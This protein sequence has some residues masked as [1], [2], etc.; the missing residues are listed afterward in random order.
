VLHAPVVVVLEMQIE[1]NE[2][3][4]GGCFG[5]A[6]RV[7]VLCTELQKEL[8]HTDG[9]IGGAVRPTLSVTFLAQSLSIGCR[10]YQGGQDT[11]SLLLSFP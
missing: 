8:G 4:G 1:V 9:D 5:D 10:C 11:A 7:V 3:S 6:D 2:C